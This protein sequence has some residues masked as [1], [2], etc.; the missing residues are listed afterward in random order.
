MEGLPRM[1]DQ[2]NAGAT[3]ETAQTWKTIHI[4]HAPIH[5]NKANMKWLWW[6]NDIRG[7][8]GPK[9]TWR[10]TGEEKTQK[11][12]S[13]RKLVPTGDRT[14]AR[15]MTNTH[16]IDCSTAVDHSVT[17]THA[18]ACSTAEENNKI[19]PNNLNIH[20]GLIFNLTTVVYYIWGQRPSPSVDGRIRF[21]R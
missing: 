11:K 21:G 19:I 4:I 6:P 7:P 14:W 15:C 10:L 8:C 12:T 3:S 17:D 13:P 16:A 20:I 18:T 1:S 2:L 5:S 9:C